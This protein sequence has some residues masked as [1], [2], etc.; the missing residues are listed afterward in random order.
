MEHCCCE[1]REQTPYC[2]ELV[3]DNPIPVL[4]AQRSH[5]SDSNQEIVSQLI[6]IQT[7][8]FTRTEQSAS[9]RNHHQFCNTRVKIKNRNS[10]SRHSIPV[11]KTE[12]LS[13]TVEI[14]Y[15][16]RRSSCS[17]FVPSQLF[18]CLNMNAYVRV[19]LLTSSE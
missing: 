3:L 14:E 12:I 7:L 16:L 15:L 5:P 10:F 19:C 4:S 6:S 8:N 1:S 9:M 17:K 18:R 11:F 13:F 2:S